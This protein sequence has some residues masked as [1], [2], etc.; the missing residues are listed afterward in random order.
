MPLTNIYEYENKNENKT[1]YI[2]QHL[3]RKCI[4]TK[5][6]PLRSK[7]ITSMSS[8]YAS[9][10]LTQTLDVAAQVNTLIHHYMLKRVVPTWCDKTLFMSLNM[11]T[12]TWDNSWKL[13]SYNSTLR[14]CLAL[15]STRCE[16]SCTGQ[17][18]GSL[19]GSP[20]GRSW[21]PRHVP[22]SPPGYRRGSVAEPSDTGAARRSPCGS[23]AGL[24]G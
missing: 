5:I 13:L 10:R 24:E 9:S 12:T 7:H 15:H 11:L 1:K 6:T 4:K 16:P 17:G 19:W 14:S 23:H 20:E 22:L 18:S 8:T 3:M 21:T 2:I